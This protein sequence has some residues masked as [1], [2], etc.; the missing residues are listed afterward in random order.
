MAGPFVYFVKPCLPVLPSSGPRCVSFA[1]LRTPVFWLLQAGN[2]IES[3]GFFILTIY[4]PTY[5]RSLGFPNVIGTIVVSLLNSTSLIGAVTIGFLVDR[6]D[7]T[8]VILISSLGATASVFLLWGLAASTPVL[9]VFS[10]MYGLFA[11]GFSASFPGIIEAVKTQSL[12]ADVGIIFSFI[13][14]GRGIGAVVSGP[15]SARMMGTGQWE[16]GIGGYGTGFAV[17]IIFTGVTAL[18]GGV[19]WVGKKAKV[20]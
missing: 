12:D 16:A 8:T 15:L 4:L 2:I 1:F 9:C 7:V 6:L 17:L 10:L 13:A 11:G 3:L 14:A 5:A 19:S 20:I 18:S